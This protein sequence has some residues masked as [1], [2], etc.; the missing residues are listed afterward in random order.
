MLL[1]S[2][3]GAMSSPKNDRRSPPAR[4][5]SWAKEVDGLE[6]FGVC[7]AKM[8]KLE[9]LELGEPGTGRPPCCFVRQSS[10]GSSCEQGF[11]WGLTP[12]YHSQTTF[13]S[14]S[15]ANSCQTRCNY[16][17]VQRAK[18]SSQ[19]SEPS[20]LS[21]RCDLNLRFVESRPPRVRLKELSVWA[22]GTFLD[23]QSRFLLL[24]SALRKAGNPVEA[25]HVECTYF[26]CLL[27]LRPAGVS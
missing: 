14:L 18:C 4:R 23:D 10:R 17:I 21:S 24:D 8:N 1:R 20:T 3:W 6:I 27:L 22:R 9:D 7:P 15:T 25:I 26:P 11:E 16:R 12:H 2:V 5:R 19:M 13:A